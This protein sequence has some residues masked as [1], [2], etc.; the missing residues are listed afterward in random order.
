[1]HVRGTRKGHGEGRQTLESSG[2]G[3]QCSSEGCVGRADI[4]ARGGSEEECCAGE[5][6]AQLDRSSPTLWASGAGKRKAQE[7]KSNHSKCDGEGSHCTEDSFARLRRALGGPSI[8]LEGWAGQISSPLSIFL[9]LHGVGENNTTLP[10]DA[11]RMEE[12]IWGFLGLPNPERAALW[13]LVEW[14]EARQES[15]LARAAL[16]SWGESST[17]RTE[18]SG[19]AS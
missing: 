14:R 3:R 1:M 9:E 7:S 10:S 6:E 12:L 18:E 17:S 13:A 11:E 19:L 5:E 2:E 16:A 4:A 8:F 15:A